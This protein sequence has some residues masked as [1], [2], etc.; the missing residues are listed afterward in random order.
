M[1]PQTIEF[2]PEV[3]MAQLQ[4]LFESLGYRLRPVARNQHKAELMSVKPNSVY[5]ESK[6]SGMSDND[7]IKAIPIG[8][9]AEAGSLGE[10]L[11][12]P[13]F[14]EDSPHVLFEEGLD[15]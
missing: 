7:F 10:A 14:E 5:S 2:P 6:L 4:P 12:N 1:K 13:V 15:K 9:V 11:R 3:T 8:T